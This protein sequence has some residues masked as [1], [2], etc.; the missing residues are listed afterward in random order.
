M[1]SQLQLHV[2]PGCRSLGCWCWCWCWCWDIFRRLPVLLCIIEMLWRPTLHPSAAPL[3][4]P[5]GQP[6][7]GLPGQPRDAADLHEPEGLP[8]A[9]GGARRHQRGGVGAGTAQ[10]RLF[11]HPAIEIDIQCQWLHQYLCMYV[12]CNAACCSAEMEFQ[13]GASAAK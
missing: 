12:L 1:L 5:A 10:Y 4:H 11:L 2:Q 3:L 6:Y 8:A 9:E 7:P 13:Y